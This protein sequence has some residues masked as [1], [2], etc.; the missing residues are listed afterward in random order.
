MKEPVRT[1]GLSLNV[2][3]ADRSV[4]TFRMGT[5]MF[6]V[7]IANVK[8][9]I[10]YSS[11][12]PVPLAQDH[13]RGVINLRGRIAPVMDLQALF[14]KRQA[15]ITR[16]SCIIIVESE[17]AEDSG[18]TGILVD[19]VSEVL[20]AR[21]EDM[22]PPPSFGSNMRHDFL[23]GMVK[24]AEGIIIILDMERLL[25]VEHPGDLS[26]DMRSFLKEKGAAGVSMPDESGVEKK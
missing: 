26:A 12:T 20:H 21:A 7:Q 15:E 17:N 2:A 3:E 25:A 18:I 24:T 23:R 4:L 14:W 10:E 11:V 5:E 19:A 6:G 9:I 8:E 1:G 22:E 16:R 13:V